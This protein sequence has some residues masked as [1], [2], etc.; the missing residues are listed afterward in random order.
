MYFW[1]FFTYKSFVSLSLMDRS[2]TAILGEKAARTQQEKI[3]RGCS[4]RDP[5]KVIQNHSKYAGINLLLK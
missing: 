1:F 2:F 5:S 4:R 3:A